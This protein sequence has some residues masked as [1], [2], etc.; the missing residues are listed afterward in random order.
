MRAELLATIVRADVTWRARAPDASAPSLDCTLTTTGSGAGDGAF[1]RPASSPGRNSL[2]GSQFE[3]KR[4]AVIVDM[5]GVRF[6]DSRR[7]PP[8]AACPIYTETLALEPKE[9]TSWHASSPDPVGFLA[10]T[11]AGVASSLP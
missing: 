4:C 6:P 2:S 11:P 8:A 1:P 9:V 5:I 10:P 3:E 7:K